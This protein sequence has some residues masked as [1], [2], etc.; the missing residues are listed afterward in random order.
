MRSSRATVVLCGF[1]LL[2]PVAARAA[3]VNSVWGGGTGNWS[4]AANWTPNTAYPN[5]GGLTYNARVAAGTVTLTEPI[6]I[7]QYTNSG[8]TLTGDFPLTINELFT[9][10]GGT[11]SGNAPIDVMAG[12]SL[13]TGSKTLTSRTLNIAGGI[14]NWG[15]GTISSGSGAVISVQPGAG[16]DA[17]FDGT[18]NVNPA[19]TT[20]FSNEGTFRKTGGTGN[21]GTVIN[22]ILNNLPGGLVQ[23]S[24]GVLNLNRGGA[25][26]GSFETAAGTTLSF[27]GGAHVL[28]SSASVTGV[29]T[30]RV[31]TGSLDVAGTYDI[32]TGSTVVSGG[33]LTLTGPNPR[34]GNL[35][36]SGNGSV[37]FDSGSPTAPLAE[38]RLGGGTLGG[39][40]PLEVSGAM[41]WSGGTLSGPGLIRPLSGMTLSGA[42]AKTLGGRTIDLAGGT[43]STWLQGA[44]NSG[45][46]AVLN[47]EPLA[48]FD[49]AF[50]G[51]YTTTAGGAST[52]TNRGTFRKS[53]G[54]GITAIAPQFLN[55]APG[56]VEVLSG[57]LSLNGGG[58]GDGVYV[59]GAGGT[60]RFGGGNHT[61]SDLSRIEGAGTNSVSAG[62][63]SIGGEYEVSGGTL[64]TGGTTTFLGPVENIGVLNLSGNPTVTFN[65]GADIPA[66]RVILAG[67]TL[68]GDDS[69]VVAGPFNWSGGRLDGGG[70]FDVNGGAT[71]TGTTKNLNA[72]ELNLNSGTTA[73]SVG[74]INSGGGAVVN[75]AG[76]FDITFDGT[77][78][79]SLGGASTF[80]NTGTLRKSGGIANS[81]LAPV[82]NNAATGTVEVDVG[83]LSLTGGGSSSGNF[84]INGGATLTF[85]GGNH[86]LD[87]AT[88]TS[89]AGTNTVTSGT[90][91]HAGA[92][93]VTG[94]TRITSG[95]A[96]FSGAVSGVGVL[97]V[98]GGTTTIASSEVVDA[99]TATVSAGT[100]SSG[101]PLNIAGGFNWT[102]GTLAGAGPINANGPATLSGGSR[103]LN[104]NLRLNAPATWSAGNINSGQGAALTIG[105]SVVL[106]ATFDGAYQFTS[107]GSSVITNLGVFRKSA[108]VG[109]NGTVVSPVFY[110]APGASVEVAT[111]TLNLN[112]GGNSGGTF[113]VAG[114]STLQ[115][116]GGSHIL[117][118]SATISGAGTNRFSSGST[119]VNGAVNVTG[120]VAV[121][122]GTATFAGAVGGGVPL[123]VTG[124]Q[125]D[126]NGTSA[127]SFSTLNL[128]GGG[129]GGTS[130]LTIAGP[131]NW[132]GGTLSGSGMLLANGGATFGNNAHTLSGRR[133]VIPTGQAALWTAGNFNADQNAVLDIAGT[134]DIG[135]DGQFF[136]GF[137]G[138]ATIENSG[139]IRKTGGNGIAAIG[140]TLNNHGTLEVT[141][142]RVDLY[143]GGTSS[144][145][146][147]AMPNSTLAF[148]TSFGA[149]PYTL[150]ADSSIEGAGTISLEGGTI[151]FAGTYDVSGTSA[152]TGSTFN[153]TSGARIQSLGAVP[154]ISGASVNFDT[155]APVGF[156]TLTVS[157][158]SLGGS[159]V[160]NITN[161]FTWSGGGLSGNNAVNALGGVSFNGGSYFLS[162]R[163]LN[164]F[165]SSTWASGDISIDSGAVF[166][167]QPG[168]TLL[169]ST[170]GT[171]GGFITTGGI[172]NSGTFR[173][174][175]GAGFTVFASRLDNLGTV[176]IGSGLLDFSFARFVQSAG[177][178]IL[179]GGNLNVGV[180]FDLLGGEL[181]GAGAVTGFITNAATIKPGAPLGIL[182]INGDL[183]QGP[184]G[185]VS[186]DLGGTVPGTGHD[187]IILT[188]PATAVLRGTLQVNRI[189]GFL[190]NVGDAFRVLTYPFRVG[191]FTSYSGF[192]LGVSDRHLEA[193][194][195]DTGL[196]LVTRDG[197]LPSD[198]PTLTIQVLPPSSLRLSWQQE[199][200]TYHLESTTNLALPTWLPFGTPGT[201]EVLVVIDFNE[202]ERYFRLAE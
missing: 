28:D 27:S 42:T 105:Q 83:N 187:Q 107:G 141:S 25:S 39:P 128:S 19:G 137:N 24:S 62:I 152:F 123:T 197:P 92:Y 70:A 171:I 143:G 43:T 73:W 58:T 41:T 190:P 12:A 154:T 53:A 162:G 193:A 97:T 124:G 9:W 127:I 75:N 164:L 13:V 199:F 78:N 84:D 133:L 150:S 103:T 4:E 82:F 182:T 121:S 77:F 16:F 181:T 166:H 178:T 74:G 85:G 34:A 14:A 195:D 160:I 156:P 129:I 52:I 116:G 104:G 144:G 94:G 93:H 125:A 56:R 46:G 147:V 120:G 109:A 117:D 134:L 99:T 29:G 168:A 114:G 106:D 132:S 6:V 155:A 110:S 90:L 40:D 184:T 122:G 108:G 81:T 179:N 136:T 112:G 188:T 157:S 135:Y 80:N 45:L 200:A 51:N 37:T 189:N 50:D 169:H 118:A 79:D 10:S 177:A 47:L 201:N 151:N 163:K 2:L 95:T 60:L 183:R 126:F 88:T 196:T 30:N 115:F 145:R 67:G 17:A 5:N 32:P 159:D 3:D 65:T 26:S 142:G 54:T 48:V 20:T 176:E 31:T 69:F 68:T 44:I 174:T 18:L 98:S 72:R 153:F 131:F 64:I 194:Y 173:K 130:D 8:G 91:S 119:V 100:L 63:V 86:T 149:S 49:S 167:I 89:G 22:A 38:L 101:G 59:A 148:V 76:L 35:F 202:F 21:A 71:F 192:D 87:A 198:G 23:V 36:M 146:F 161:L 55:V 170:D 15:A 102:G 158:G 139:T 138:T 165:G 66:T 191:E 11:I 61:L 180:G 186:I 1:A 140:V 57:T 113:S 175:G 172:T 33:S 96:S 185:V 111:G 7:Q